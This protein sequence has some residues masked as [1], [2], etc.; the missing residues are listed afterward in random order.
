MPAKRNAK[1]PTTR[2]RPPA[3]V[4]RLS[5][6]DEAAQ[7]IRGLIFDGDLTP[8]DRVPQDEVASV[9][10]VSRIPVREALITLESEGWVTIE[11]NRG[12]FVNGYDAN[13]VLDHYDLFGMIYGFAARRALVRSSGQ[14]LADHLEDVVR[15]TV[16]EE[17]PARMT[18]LALAFNR[19]VI[20]AAGS[21]RIKSV[22]RGLGQ[23]VPGDFFSMVPQ[24][25][26]VQRKGMR[27]V[28]RAIKKGD[29]DRADVEYRKLMHA[30]GTVVFALLDE[31]GVLAPGPVSDAAD[32]GSS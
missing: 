13:S 3:T 27:A 21:P 1:T 32:A 12:A 4:V 24:A 25:I 6:G 10:G 15:Q 11:L 23:L 18:Q 16:H 26:D 22:T 31:R 5:R 29:A 8:G 14:E 28:A 30:V 20:G 19:A 9:L 17:D 7:Y 2:L